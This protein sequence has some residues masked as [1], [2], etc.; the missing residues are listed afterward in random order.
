MP[1]AASC[2]NVSHAMVE[3][4]KVV[5]LAPLPANGETDDRPRPTPRI[6]RM[7]DSAA[8]PAEPARIAP[9]DTPD[10]ACRPAATSSLASTRDRAGPPARRSFCIMV[11]SVMS[12]SSG[13]FDP[14]AT[15]TDGLCALVNRTRQQSTL[16]RDAD[17]GTHL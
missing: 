9:H 2:V 8:A 7:S 1:E 17:S 5:A 15:C 13:C 11:A 10:V 16:L 12:L 14:G 4:P 6:N 3:T